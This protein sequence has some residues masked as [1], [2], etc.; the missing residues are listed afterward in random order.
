MSHLSQKTMAFA[1]SAACA[2][3]WS[4]AAPVPTVKA[5]VKALAVA[6]D[7]LKKAVL[8]GRVATSGM[9]LQLELEGAETM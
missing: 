1:M 7:P 8:I 2:A 3:A 9:V 5:Q 6:A 4:Q